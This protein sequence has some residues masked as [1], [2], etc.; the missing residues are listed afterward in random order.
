MLTEEVDEYIPAEAAADLVD[1]DN[2]GGI[3]NLEASE[4]SELQRL[5]A[6]YL[7][8]KNRS[9][10]FVDKLARVMFADERVRK[11]CRVRALKN[12]A[13][14]RDTEDVL[15]RVMIVFFDSQLAKLREADAV[16]AVI[17]AIA[18]NV[19]REV[20]RDSLTLTVN[21][22]SIEEMRDR[23]EELEQ[24]SFVDSEQLDRDQQLDSQIAAAKMALAYQRHLN[25]EQKLNNHGVFDLDPL[26]ASGVAAPPSTPEEDAAI[27]AA[28][29]NRA[30][31]RRSGAASTKDLSAEQQELVEICGQLG[32]RNQDFAASLG[33]G[34]PRLSS[35]IYGRTAT[36]PDDI[37]ELARKL[38]DEDPET[39][40]RQK[41]FDIPMSELLNQWAKDLEVDNDN[42]LAITLG[43][44]KMTI[45][46]WRN[47]ET[48]P[49]QTSLSRY[50]QQVRQY[51]MRQQQLNSRSK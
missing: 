11:I 21:H 12:G 48:K 44:T 43:V 18:N 37:M 27:D 5:C 49:D 50:E 7:A 17:Y 2:E 42:D 32:M 23:G 39:V 41:R 16:Y 13:D 8:G 34:L 15:Q 4:V 14:L 33:I 1:D 51:K 19:S 29:K 47:N 31:T 6:E 24:S 20:V 46:R 22:D 9:R 26:M 38:R 10:A 3:G 35:Y 45:H 25:G 30:R 28:L 36:V 40:D